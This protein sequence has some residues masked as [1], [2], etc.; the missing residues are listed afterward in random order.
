VTLS[1]PQSD[2][3][4]YRP[5]ID[6]LRAIAVL[7]VVFVHAG[8]GPPAGFVGVDVFF[9]ISGYLMTLLLETEWIALGRIDPWAFFARRIR[10][11]FPML[12]TVVLA[13]SVASCFLLSPYGELEASL[14]SAASS[15]VFAAN[16]FFQLHSGGYFD[17]RSDQMPLLHLW[18]LG[19]E[20]QFY[21]LWPLFYIFARRLGAR[22]F[23]IMV[24]VLSLVSLAASEL[25][26][27]SGSQAAFFSL[28]SRWWELGMGAGIALMARDRIRR[29]GILAATGTV[30]VLL[31]NCLPTNHFPGVGALPAAL[32]SAAIL[33][34][35]HSRGAL[36]IAGRVLASRLPSTIGRLSY[37]LYLWH[38]PLLA[39]ASA[40]H[41][42]SLPMA[43][44]AGLV[45][46]ALLL[47]AISY[48]WIET[49]F[50]QPSDATQP[51]SLV[52]TSAVASLAFA[53]ALLV[54]GD[55]FAMTPP[56]SDL[57]SRTERDQPANEFACHYRGDQPI[58]PFPREDCASSPSL[59]VRVA[60]WGD[61]HALA[62][63]P[64]AWAIAEQKGVAA[65]PFTRD[66]CAPAIDYDNGKRALESSRCK[67]FNA[68]VL[69]RLEGMDTVVLT[70]LW[71]ETS[72]GDFDA[73]LKETLRRLAP[74][75]QHVILLGQTPILPEQAPMCIRK[76]MLDAC[77]VQR[78]VFEKQ[79]ADRRALLTQLA[80][81][82]Q[83]VT[84]V[85]PAPFF[86]GAKQCSAV[87]DGYGL[88]WDNNHVTS[89][90]ARHFAAAYIASRQTVPVGPIPSI[91]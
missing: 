14:R 25:L 31:A 30:L 85:D 21:L 5:E 22:P 13:T 88:Y 45:V 81:Q 53:F 42:G 27:A 26:I 3:L 60:I 64:F 86:C 75:V 66:S 47:S 90:A 8:F 35:V 65:E 36:G 82:F 1:P 38:W 62:M 41:A 20:E 69:P 49:P 79:F 18:S 39:L 4:S 78:D 80:S 9:V 11:L 32:G 48:R 6:G 16:I 73:H 56:P 87:K 46:A 61:S 40:S 76:G 57:A 59:P 10:R 54:L 34:G 17:P 63:Q 15:L 29:P 55:S 68:R 89:T 84:Y 43:T 28:P 67:E 58:D 71:P 7:A 72:R 12:I 19:V 50:R 91:P 37:S 2:P 70:A 83:N 44:R 23:R 33:L 74:T 77:D 52:T 24:A 51:R